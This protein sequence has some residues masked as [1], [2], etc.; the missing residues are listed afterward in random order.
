M[1]T[2][3]NNELKEKHIPKQNA[4][5]KTITEFAMTFDKNKYDGFMEIPSPDSH[6]NTLT[7]YRV[8]LMAFQRR[9]RGDYTPNSN[10][11]DSA[12]K[13]VDKIRDKVINQDFD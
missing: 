11:L 1:K 12:R 3:S 6:H 8:H 10:Q 4:D 5:F 9:Y 2:I 7:T 13:V